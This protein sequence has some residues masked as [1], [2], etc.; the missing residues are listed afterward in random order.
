MKMI[1]IAG[2]PVASIA[3]PAPQARL[4][5]IRVHLITRPDSPISTPMAPFPIADPMD[6][7]GGRSGPV[8]VGHP[9]ATDSGSWIPGLA[10]LGSAFSPGVGRPTTMGDGFSMPPAAAGFIPPRFP[11]DTRVIRLVR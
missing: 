5:N 9:S 10:G 8:L 1:L 7:V 4:C 11:T 2:F 6:T 3:F